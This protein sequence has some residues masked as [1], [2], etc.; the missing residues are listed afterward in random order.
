MAN[1]TRSFNQPCCT[2]D[3]ST[4]DERGCEGLGRRCPP[5]PWSQLEAAVTA[6]RPPQQ[7]APEI[8]PPPAQIHRRPT[9]PHWRLRAPGRVQD[10]R[11][12]NPLLVEYRREWSSSPRWSR[13]MSAREP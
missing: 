5:F 4:R 11:D 10:L 9:R 3:G 6:Y 12:R 7:E 1:A 13:R 2:G 8:W